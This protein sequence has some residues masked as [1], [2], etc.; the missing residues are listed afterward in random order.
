MLP[1]TQNLR[2]LQQE[3]RLVSL[4]RDMC[5]EY[6]IQAFILS[7]SDTLVFVQ[8]IDDF[9]LDGFYLFRRQDIT[10]IEVSET[11][12]FHK[13]LL[14]E[15]G[16]FD[17]IPFQLDRP[18]HTYE[19]FF[20]SIPEDELVAVEDELADEPDYLLGTVRYYDEERLVMR[21]LSTTA[22]WYD[23]PSEMAMEDITSV[24]IHTNYLKTYASHL[25][26]RPTRSEVSK[27]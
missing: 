8:E 18:Y 27:S 2:R 14:T 23:E 7:C 25:R 4:H 17:Q 16:T 19:E 12:D 3:K 24:Q 26:Q 22:Q 11:N 20:A 6:S 21:Y 10:Q 5:C 15:A 1:T 9:F 13:H